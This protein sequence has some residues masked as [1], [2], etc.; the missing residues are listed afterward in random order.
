VGKREFADDC[1]LHQDVLGQLGAFDENL[2]DDIL[3]VAFI[4]DLLGDADVYFDQGS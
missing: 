3:D 4:I 2:V 1:V